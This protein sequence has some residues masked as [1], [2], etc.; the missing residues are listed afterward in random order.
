MA[1]EIAVIVLNW[2]NAVDTCRCLQSLQESDYRTHRVIIVDNGSTDDSVEIILRRYP[3]VTLLET[4]QNLGY[5]GGNNVGIRCALYHNAEYIFILNNDVVLASDTLGKLIRSCQ[6][7]SHV[8]VVG[9]KIFHREDPQRIQSAGGIVDDRGDCHFRFVDEIDIGVDEKINHPTTV[10][11][12]SGCAMLI[13]RA[14][15]ETTTGFDERFFMYYE[16]VDLCYRARKAGFTV[17][18]APLARAWHRRP[19]INSTTPPYITYYMNRNH[20]L[21]LTKNRVSKAN[22]WRHIAFKQLPWVANWTLNPK[23]RHK[24][25]ERN[26]LVRAIIDFAQNQF[27]QVCHEY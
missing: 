25:R 22:A 4:H 23:W 19:D 7:R 13:S 18:Y 10:D 20:L 6:D 2:N 12:V 17:L 14:C 3:H 21:F 8:G 5:A 1:P 24:R 9:P 15:L 16:D 26:A 27:G 11:F